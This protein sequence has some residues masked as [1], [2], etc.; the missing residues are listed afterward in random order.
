[1]WHDRLK[2]VLN[3]KGELRLITIAFLRTYVMKM[4]TLQAQQLIEEA[5][6]LYYRKNK[7]E[8]NMENMIQV[9]HELAHDTRVLKKQ[10]LKNTDP[11]VVS[12]SDDETMV[13]RKDKDTPLDT[14]EEEMVQ[15][16][17]QE[18]QEDFMHE[19]L[20]WR[21]DM[22]FAT[23]SIGLDAPMPP[24]EDEEK[25][26][27]SDDE[28]EEQDSSESADS[29]LSRE[30]KDLQDQMNALDEE[31]K[32]GCTALEEVEEALESMESK[33]LQE[34][35]ESAEVAARLVQL[36]RD[37]RHL[38]EERK[39]MQM[40]KA[41]SQNARVHASESREQCFEVARDLHNDGQNLREDIADLMA[42]KEETLKHRAMEERSMKLDIREL[43]RDVADERGYIR[44]AD[45][46]RAR[47][48]RAL[49]KRVEALHRATAAQGRD[50]K[51]GP[52][53]LRLCGA[54]REMLEEIRATSV[55]LAPVE[56]EVDE[57]HDS[58]PAEL[59]PEVVEL[60]EPRSMDQQSAA[61]RALTDS[62]RLG[63]V[64]EEDS[65]AD[66]S[67]PD[68]EMAAE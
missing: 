20:R 21:S 53:I 24:D 39:R 38:A 37:A 34:S 17:T 4:R 55:P 49:L 6:I 30:S 41:L 62:N 7:E 10:M 47:G 60:S 35:Q 19:I 67:L 8:S 40:D 31:L 28:E 22:T 18:L 64:S 66:L 63:A 14:G 27:D 3:E 11:D 68:L 43:E 13:H 52:D 12:E 25:K 46:L 50:F 2:D 26:P 15:F 9:L 1:M 58:M 57:F 42:M 54:A 56:Q 29:Q 51:Q 16:H 44:E 36:K 45:G 59:Q 23:L 32:E 33:L 5:S 61:L 48:Y 65:E